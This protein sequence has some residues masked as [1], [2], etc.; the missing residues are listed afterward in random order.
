MVFAGGLE[1][2]A[3]TMDAPAVLSA[4]PSPRRLKVGD[5]VRFVSLPE[6]WR[7]C[8]SGRS[9]R[10][11]RYIVVMV[12]GIF[13]VVFLAMIVGCGEQS[14]PAVP[15]KRIPNAKLRIE[16]STDSRPIKQGAIAGLSAVLVNDG[17]EAAIIVLPGDGSDHG[18]RTPVVRWNPPMSKGGCGNINPLSRSQVVTLE[19]GYEIP[20]GRAIG[21]PSL[22][23][24][25][26]HH[27]SLELQNIPD[28]VWRGIPL[29][30]HDPSAMEM[31]RRS[32]PFKIVSNVVEVELK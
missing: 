5:R 20:L 15:A 32:T 25:G 1:R 21:W 27:V 9:S 7:R 14:S 12:R 26:R 19:P 16:L 30:E 13:A 3:R 31:V 24:V 29:G 11:F 4:M 28:L 10:S 17:P 2:P 22:T 8:G 18:L 23:E 6:E